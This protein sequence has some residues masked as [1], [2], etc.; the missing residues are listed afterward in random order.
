VVQRL[1]FRGYLGLGARDL[2]ENLVRAGESDGTRG[3][4]SLADSPRE[5]GLGCDNGLVF[6]IA[7]SAT[8]Y[9]RES[10]SG[11]TKDRPRLRF[12]VWG[13]AHEG[14][15]RM[16]TVDSLDHKPHNARRQEISLGLQNLL[17]VVV[18]SMSWPYRHKPASRRRASRAPRPDGLTCAIRV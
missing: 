17:G 16:R 18:A 9:G 8:I 5:T 6:R 2:L 1:G 14:P 15:R 11:S 12:R 13:L 3:T 10:W 4:A 7:A